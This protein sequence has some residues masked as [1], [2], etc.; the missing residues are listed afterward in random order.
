MYLLEKQ[1]EKA[2]SRLT[3]IPVEMRDGKSLSLEEYKSFASKRQPL[4]MKNMLKVILPGKNW[5]LNHINVSFLKKYCSK[6]LFYLDKGR[7]TLKKKVLNE[8]LL[9]ISFL[10]FS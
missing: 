9:E 2:G 8:K 5:D 4:I 6:F 7:E 3:A 10:F 1:F